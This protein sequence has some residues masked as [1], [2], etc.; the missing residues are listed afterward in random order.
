MEISPLGEG[1]PGKNIL[2]LLGDRGSLLQLFRLQLSLMSRV[3]YRKVRLTAV[4]PALL[5]LSSCSLNVKVRESWR[6]TLREPIPLGEVSQTWSQMRS[7]RRPD[8]SSLRAYNA[9][10]EGSVVQI[11]KNW[12][13]DK[14]HL[15]SIPTTSGS[16]NFRVDTANVMD[17]HLVD[18]VVPAD[19]VKV[20]QGFE[21]ESRVDGVG[22]SL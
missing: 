12:T 10:V 15:S 19:V 9:A 13:K 8:D 21:S 18:E 4:L 14:D 6:D 20:R 16:L 1:I 22:T 7:G 2:G 11:A 17:L 5:L 3:C